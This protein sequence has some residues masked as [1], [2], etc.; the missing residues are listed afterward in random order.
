MSL[1]VYVAALVR[2]H[3]SL[4][5]TPPP[6]SA[7][8]PEDRKLEPPSTATPTR[9][10]STRPSPTRTA[11]SSRERLPAKCY[12]VRFALA[13]FVRALK[14]GTAKI[15]YTDETSTSTTSTSSTV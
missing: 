10:S 3:E 9:T 7:V 14:T 12:R 4:H 1:R 2:V 11:T 15:S 6:K 8:N 13:A 5:R